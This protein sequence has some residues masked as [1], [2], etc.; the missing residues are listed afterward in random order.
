MLTHL[1]HAGNS[2]G[3]ACRNDR[4]DI[5]VNNGLSPFGPFFQSPSQPF[6]ALHL[7]APPCYHSYACHGVEGGFDHGISL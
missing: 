5:I 3:S 2:Q 6:Q 7:T 4:Q 1:K